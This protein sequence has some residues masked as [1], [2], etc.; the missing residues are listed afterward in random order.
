MS[1]DVPNADLL[2]QYE[3]LIKGK[4]TIKKTW[5]SS[6]VTGLYE[7]FEGSNCILSVSGNGQ[8]YITQNPEYAGSTGILA[9][10]SDGKYLIIYRES[11][12]AN[13]YSKT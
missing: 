2:K 11:A 12:G 6:S 4:W 13:V 7:S 5:K 10:S 9:F 1:M 3:E 8:V